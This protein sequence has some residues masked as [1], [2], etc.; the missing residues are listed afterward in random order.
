LEVAAPAGNPD[1]DLS[2]SAACRDSGC[3]ANANPIVAFELTWHDRTSDIPRWLWDA[4]F[5]PPKEGLF[6]FRA[7]EAGKLEQQF[8]F[9]FGLLQ[10]DGVAVG[11]IPAFLHDLSLDLVIP[12]AI[13]RFVKP[14]ARGPLRRLGYQRTLFV[15]N[16]AGEEGHI[17]LVP[18]HTLRASAPFIQSALRKKARALKAPMLVWKDFP[19]EVR[20]AL[21]EG[22]V[23]G[24]AFRIPSYPSTIIPLVRG[25]YAAFLATQ[26]SDRRRKINS[27]LRRSANTY[28]VTTAVVARPDEDQLGEIFT[29]FQQTYLRGKTKFERLTP[30]YF[31]AIAECDESTFIVQRDATSGKMVAFMLMLNLGQRMINQFIGID[32]GATS[33]GFPHFRLF[34]AAY[35]WACATPATVLQSGQT[36]Y[37]AKLDIGHA[38]VP[39][40]NYCEHRN[41]AV[42]WIYRKGA[43]G[44][45]W[46]TLDDQ[47]AEYLKAH[48]EGR[49]LV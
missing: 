47:L 25:G 43:A 13:A 11:I 36:G 48:P 3:V 24:G 16:V 4:C 28:A 12:P 34:A 2:D 22:L 6:W 32:Y 49:G 29:L 40:W 5:G 38:L 7:L 27:K 31:H 10:Q 42:N 30:E 18:G 39:L 19:S 21:D 9:L 35:D 14:L 23:T 8:A 44:I 46:E 37:M 17:G 33:G 26:R 41:S 45:G 15:G 1:A 20:E